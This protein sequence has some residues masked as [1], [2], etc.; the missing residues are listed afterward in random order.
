[1]A[2]INHA[3]LERSL[4]KRT[5]IKCATC[6]HVNWKTPHSLTGVHVRGLI[7]C[8]AA[9]HHFGRPVNRDEMN[10]QRN[11]NGNF[12]ALRWWGLIEQPKAPYWNITP[13]GW[14]FL[15]HEKWVPAH[16]W[17]IDG[18]VVGVDPERVSVR[19][20]LNEEAWQK[21]EYVT[22]RVPIINQ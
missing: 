11:E 17:T 13:D 14:A 9:I 16:V 18:E 22:H 15:R 4:W 10:L 20:S 7:K 2:T 12:S 1:M 6:G 3:R 19:K 5:P 21:L 8:A